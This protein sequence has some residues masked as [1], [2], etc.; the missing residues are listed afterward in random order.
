MRVMTVH[1][2]ATK[3]GRVVPREA[4]YRT[5]SPTSPLSHTQTGSSSEMMFQSGNGV[6]KVMQMGL[7][8]H[9]STRSPLAP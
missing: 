7:R 9:G 2:G 3:D 6:G 4:A 1:P 8:R 5:Q